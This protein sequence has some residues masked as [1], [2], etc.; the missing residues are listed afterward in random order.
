LQHCNEKIE[1]AK[2]FQVSQK[3]CHLAYMTADVVSLGVEN[4]AGW[5]VTFDKEPT[6]VCV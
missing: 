1:I 3:S 4:C 2:E 5:N 6:T